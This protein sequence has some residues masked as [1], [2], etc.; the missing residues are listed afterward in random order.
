MTLAALGR[1]DE[2]LRAYDATVRADPDWGM[3]QYNRGNLLRELGRWEEAR[4]SFADAVRCAPEQP[5]PWLNY[6]VSLDETGRHAEAVYAYDR[7]LALAPDMAMAWSNRGQQPPAPRPRDR[8]H[9]EL[10]PCRGAGA[11]VVLG[12]HESGQRAA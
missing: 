6:G 2:A 10:P 3:P 4:A 9:P 11:G 8:G 7:A 5:A 1:T 12:S